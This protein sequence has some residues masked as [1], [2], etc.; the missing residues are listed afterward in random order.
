M[1]ARSLDMAES[2]VQRAQ[3]KENEA[4]AETERG[5]YAESISASQECIELSMKTIFLLLTDS[6][7][8]RHDFKEEEF[9]PL[10]DRIP[11][12]LQYYNFPRL[13]L[14]HRLWS[15]FYTVSKYGYDKFGTGP[16]KLFKKEE[17]ELALR[18]AGDCRHAA[19][20]LFQRI[21]YP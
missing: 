17:A 4:R 3:N 14:L 1:S 11:K 21:K 19:Y 8:R 2:F 13:Y 9:E 12:E 20:A 10:L 7:P 16:E 5:H 15:G 18:H 6:Y